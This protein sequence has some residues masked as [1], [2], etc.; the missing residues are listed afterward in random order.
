MTLKNYDPKQ[1]LITFGAIII[2]GFADGVFCKVERT[3]E[4]FNTKA[5]ADGE[6][7]RTRTNDNRGKIT[8]T[9]MQS[10]LSNDLLSAQHSLDKALPLGLGTSHLLIKDL[11]GRTLCEAPQSWIVKEPDQEFGKEAADREWVLEASDLIT[12][13]GGN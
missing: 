1:V 7:C 10:S 5:G 9:L 3:S 4:A 8:I 11:S 12:F 6:V 13:V 2:G